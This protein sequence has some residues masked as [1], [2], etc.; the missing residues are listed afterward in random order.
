MAAQCSF[1]Q[2]QMQSS[3]IEPIAKKTYEEY[4]IKKKIF[5]QEK[6]MHTRDAAAEKSVPD[7]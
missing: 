2:S 1:Q 4:I 3:E 6:L 5:E 7:L